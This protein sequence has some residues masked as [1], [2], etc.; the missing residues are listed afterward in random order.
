MLSPVDIIVLETLSKHLLSANYFHTEKIHNLHLP[1]V[2]KSVLSMYK[3]KS[4]RGLRRGREIQTRDVRSH[5]I[6]L[7]YDKPNVNREE[8]PTWTAAASGRDSRLLYWVPSS[9]ILS[10]IQKD[11]MRGKYF[12][13]TQYT[14][15]THT[16][17]LRGAGA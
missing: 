2:N 13:M 10:V 1:K 7:A 16:Y 17:T 12:R 9:L 3:E 11:L 5:C 4:L 8:F 14:I 6:C 15:N